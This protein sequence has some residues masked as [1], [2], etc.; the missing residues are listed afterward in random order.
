MTFHVLDL[1]TSALLL[2]LDRAL[3]HGKRSQVCFSSAKL[4]CNTKCQMTHE[5]LILKHNEI[6]YPTL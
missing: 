1:F 2:Q 3:Q 5:V 6:F 4:N